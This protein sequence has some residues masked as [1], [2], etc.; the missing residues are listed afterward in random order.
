MPDP[1]SAGLAALS[2]GLR[3]V[4][5][6][7]NLS[8]NVKDWLKENRDKDVGRVYYKVLELMEKRAVLVHGAGLADK[9]TNAAVDPVRSPILESLIKLYGTNEET[10][11]LNASGIVYVIKDKSGNGKSHA[12]RAL[13]QNFY[14]LDNGDSI[15]GFM[16]SGDEM[17]DDIPAELG[18][19]LG[20]TS[21]EG[22]IHILLLAMSMPVQEH[23]SILIIDSFNSLGTDDVNLKFIKALY[24]MMNAKKNIFVV[25]LTQ[26]DS[27]AQKL[28]DCNGGNRVVPLPGC[29]KG[30]L[31]SLTWNETPWTR[32]Q[33]IGAIRYDLA[34]EG[35]ENYYNE[36]DFSFLS[37]R[38]TPLQAIKKMR[39]RLRR[40][41]EEPDSPRKKRAKPS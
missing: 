31:T 36:Q 30:E 27:V 5:G 6:L 19:Q 20:A 22:W 34:S 37:D 11:E 26:L 2:L 39:T 9:P 25:V 28:V 23:P 3:T 18:R 32:E 35:V 13:L 15:K 24:S 21:V 41:K 1:I 8:N 38:M 14:A 17:D 33:L 7:S 40:S 16:I 10:D 29:S 4:D 12:G